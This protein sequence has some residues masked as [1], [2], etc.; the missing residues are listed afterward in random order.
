[1]IITKTSCVMHRANP[2][3]VHPIY[4]PRFQWLIHAIVNIVP[5]SKPSLSLSLFRQQYR[6]RSKDGVD[7]KDAGRRSGDDKG[8]RERAR[9]SEDRGYRKRVRGRLAEAAT[10][11][12]LAEH[13]Q[14]KHV[15]FNRQRTCANAVSDLKWFAVLTGTCTWCERT[16]RHL[17]R[18]HSIRPSSSFYWPT[19]LSRAERT[20]CSPDC[21]VKQKRTES[22]FFLRDLPIVR[23]IS[24]FECRDFMNC[25]WFSLTSFG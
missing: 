13:W 12:S 25:L 10:I 1:M 4:E 22:L 5:D 9:G 14:C 23:I 3:I 17:P 2:I 21:R 8:S 6:I 24:R 7:R 19:D 18:R 15:H 16:R 11:G 20:R